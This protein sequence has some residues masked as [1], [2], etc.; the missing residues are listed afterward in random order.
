MD[1]SALSDMN[2]N[3]LIKKRWSPRAFSQEI[4]DNEHI[5]SILEAARWSASCNNEQPW[6][7]LVGIKNQNEIYQKIFEVLDVGNQV[8]AKSAPVLIMLFAKKTFSR[9]DKPNNWAK[10]DTGQAAANMSIQ[11]MD[12]N[13]YVH[14]MAGFDQY[15]ASMII[16]SEEEL[17][18][19]TAMAL[20]FLGNP[21][22]LPE[23]LRRTELSSRKRKNLNEVVLNELHSTT[24][25]F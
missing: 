22:Q 14:Q 1:K 19:V 21:E 8:W 23:D 6:R 16:K 10:Y 9:N 24:E 13:I 25:A 5:G 4:P 20:G 7:F 12:L 2:L 3:V 15:A 18:P 11:A 17:V